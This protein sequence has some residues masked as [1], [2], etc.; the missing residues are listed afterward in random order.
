MLPCCSSR[1]LGREEFPREGIHGC[2]NFWRTPSSTEVTEQFF[3]VSQFWGRH[4]LA[5]C[6]VSVCSSALNRVDECLC[7]ALN[8]R[9]S[10]PGKSLST[11][12]THC[13]W[14]SEPG[15]TST[16]CC[17]P[18]SSK[19]AM[20]ASPAR[21]H[22]SHPDFEPRSHDPRSQVTIRWPKQLRNEFQNNS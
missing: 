18:D 14:A 17:V 11:C 13:C 1:F 8:S 20:A 10:A 4:Q 15:A 16:L 7:P 9:I 12:W 21:T 6:A 3:E 5:S 19:N 22:T 2:C